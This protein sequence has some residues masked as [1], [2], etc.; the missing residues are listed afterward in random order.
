MN[1]KLNIAPD[2]AL[3]NYEI[4]IGDVYLATS[5]F[6]TLNPSDAYSDLMVEDTTLGDVNGDGTISPSDAVMVLYHFFNVEQTGFNAKAA[7][8]NGDGTVT[9]ADAIETLYM[10]FGAGSNAARQ[11]KQEGEPQ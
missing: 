9:P 10:Y 6:E 3:G 7:D 1:V 8:V 4:G 2:V 11:K 5:T